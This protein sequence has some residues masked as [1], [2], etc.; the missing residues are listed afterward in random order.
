MLKIGDFSRLSRV[1]IRMLRYYDD[2]DL[3]KP[4][5]VDPL[6]GYRYYKEDQL[7]IIGKIVSLKNMG[8]G[9]A[10][11]KEIMKCEDNPAEIEHI[12]QIQKIQLMEEAE[13][14]NNRIKLLD[15]AVKML[16]KDEA[17]KYDCA[18]KNLP[19]RY[20]ASVRRIIP[21]YEEEG[22]LWHDLFS[23]TS[24][25]N[26]VPCGPAMAVL[27]DR[28]YKEND[29]DVEVQIEVKGQFA[30]TEHV[31]FKTEP[32]VQMASTTFNG[33]YEQFSKVYA[34]LAAWVSEN[35]YVFCG[36][37][38]DIYHVSPNETRNPDEFVTEVCCPVKRV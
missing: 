32:A 10:A 13:I 35:G 25:Q 29:V 5:M 17:M 18:I 21:K 20:V 19:E 7:L 2:A 6:T 28:E 34:S 26:M 1:S 3:I 14:I 37:M 12:F 30:D 38:M 27:H 9:V 11:I 23:E 24:G 15:T 36:P 33:S 4:V 8:F 31:K 22:R 16:G